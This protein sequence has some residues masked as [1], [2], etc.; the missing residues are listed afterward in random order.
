MFKKAASR[1]RGSFSPSSPVHSRSHSII[2]SSPAS[3][4][5]TPRSG[6]GLPLLVA[7]VRGGGASPT[8]AIGSQPLMKCL[9]CFFAIGRCHSCALLSLFVHNQLH[10]LKGSSR[11]MKRQIRRTWWVER[12][13]GKGADQKRCVSGYTV[14]AAWH[15]IAEIVGAASARGQPVQ[16]QLPR[17][18]NV[19]RPTG[20]PRMNYRAVR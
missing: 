15:M 7:G 8:G 14:S 9:C 1:G 5:P 3:H 19:R 13:Y 4:L 10:Q 17:L 12:Q 18:I 20:R 11:A 2:S 6:A 16:A